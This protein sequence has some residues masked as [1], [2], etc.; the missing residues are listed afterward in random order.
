MPD[1]LPSLWHVTRRPLKSNGQVTLIMPKCLGSE[2]QQARRRRA[3]LYRL[4]NE[5]LTVGPFALNKRLVPTFPQWL[6]C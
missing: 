3:D 4:P 1:W 6:F 2:L 5:D